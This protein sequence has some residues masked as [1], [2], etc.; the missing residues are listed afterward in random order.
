M[1]EELS[2]IKVRLAV[3]CAVT[4]VMLVISGLTALS[5]QRDAAET[6]AALVERNETDRTMLAIKAD[7]AKSMFPA[8]NYLIEKELGNKETELFRMVKAIRK[9][10]ERLAAGEPGP[11]RAGRDRR[12]SSSAG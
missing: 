6:T 3:G 1:K 7:I 2:L 12:C 5:I 8:H 4:T 9:D 10:M 11:S